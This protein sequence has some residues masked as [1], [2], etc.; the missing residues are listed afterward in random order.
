MKHL[1]TATASAL[2]L[3]ASA[4]AAPETYTL[5][6]THTN[7]VW[8]AN[9]LGFSNPSG[10][11]VEAT[12]QLVLD[13][14]KP[15]NS[16]VS[17]TIRPGSVLTGIPKFDEHLRSA[18]FFESEKF[19]EA[20]FKSTK[21]D[22]TGEKTAKVYGE[23]TLK[24]ITKPVVL[25]VVLNQIAPNPMTGKKTAG[26]SATT[27]IKRSEFGITYAIPG[28]SDAVTIEIEVEG[29]VNG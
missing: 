1:L 16:T 26:F 29:N 21:V 15:E 3:A 24:G 28:V 13:E 11:F 25:D 22:V 27:T 4:H 5:D 6:P 12:G 7:I 9:H 20:V 14:A 19:P 17:V 10:K 8:K 18:D 2:L 23:L